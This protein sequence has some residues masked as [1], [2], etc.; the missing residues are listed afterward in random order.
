[1]MIRTPLMLA[2]GLASSMLMGC[3]KPLPASD[4]S[5]TDSSSDS[6]SETETETETETDSETG[7]FGGGEPLECM[8]GGN[9]SIALEDSLASVVGT[10][11]DMLPAQLACILEDMQT[12]WWPRKVQ[13]EEIIDGQVRATT[14]YVDTVGGAV[15]MQSIDSEYVRVESCELAPLEFFAAC[16]GSFSAECGDLDNW[17]GACTSEVSCPAPPDCGLQP[18]CEPTPLI[19]PDGHDDPSCVWAALRDADLMTAEVSVDWELT[20]WEYRGY[21][22]YL[23]GQS[24]NVGVTGWAVTDTGGGIYIK[25]CELR[26]AAFFQACLDAPTPECEELS[27]WGMSWFTS[28]VDSPHPCPE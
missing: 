6:D 27:S 25:R 8:I 24:R 13:I 14:L 7:E 16:A 15:V 19:G 18:T 23:N 1:M 2:T 17:F 5:E 10:S 21:T 20:N 22:F 11:S 28:C 12:Q 9:C 26:D 3:A 4:S